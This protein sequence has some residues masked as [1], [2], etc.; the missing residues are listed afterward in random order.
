LDGKE[1]YEVTV[2]GWNRFN[3]MQWSA[4]GKNL[5]VKGSSPTMDAMLQIDTE[6]RARVLLESGISPSY[7]GAIPSPDGRYLALR[8]WTQN[9]NIWMIED[10]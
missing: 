4:D 6:G 8:A 1:A 7:R 9:K 5:Y 3:S 10:F 2:N